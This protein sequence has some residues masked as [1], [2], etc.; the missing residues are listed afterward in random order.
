MYSATSC[1]TSWKLRYVKRREQRWS[2]PREEKMKM[3]YTKK[4]RWR[5]RRR[6]FRICYG[7]YS[8]C[9]L[10]LCKLVFCSVHCMDMRKFWGMSLEFLLLG[11]SVFSIFWDLPFAS[12]HMVR[13]WISLGI[14]GK[15][16]IPFYPRFVRPLGFLSFLFPLAHSS[17]SLF[18]HCGLRYVMRVYEQ[19]IFASVA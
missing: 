8:N 7:L 2:V 6:L 14:Y 13:C 17:S 4:R 19:T 1:A 9:I 18:I 15:Y 5:R 3:R 16:W 10:D 12:S 11:S